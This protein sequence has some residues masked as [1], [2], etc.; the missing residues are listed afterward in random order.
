[1]VLILGTT[2][3]HEYG[4]Y[5]TTDGVISTFLFSF[6]D[7][8]TPIIT[9]ARGPL[10][11]WLDAVLKIAPLPFLSR[12]TCLVIS[13]LRVNSWVLIKFVF[14]QAAQ[15]IQHFWGSSASLTD[16]LQQ[17]P[18]I[19]TWPQVKLKFAKSQWKLLWFGLF[20]LPPKDT[21]KS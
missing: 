13:S 4:F 7:P 15:S 20:F 3:S 10:R 6:L 16:Q 9:G 17:T 18:W 11:N 12:V 1:M 14:W 8:F 19:F 5:N 21:L 2:G